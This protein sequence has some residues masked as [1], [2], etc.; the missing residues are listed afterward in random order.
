[1]RF[2]FPRGRVVVRDGAQ[3]VTYRLDRAGV[4]VPLSGREFR[5]ALRPQN[6]WELACEQGRLPASSRHVEVVE[7]PADAR[8]PVHERPAS[9]A[10]AR[11]GT[12]FCED[13]ASL[14]LTHCPRC[15]TVLQ[16]A[17][18]R[19]RMVRRVRS[20]L[21]ILMSLFGGLLGAKLMLVSLAVGLVA[22]ALVTH[23]A[24]EAP[25]ER[26]ANWR[27]GFVFAGAFALVLALSWLRG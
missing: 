20:P 5:L 2:G 22:G 11:C 3:K 10:C 18:D 26:A 19:E 27:A 15:V 8:C 14:D 6:E 25:S 7:A 4:R 24:R 23:L 12:F 13:C 16:A 9:R 1:M 17:D 21:A